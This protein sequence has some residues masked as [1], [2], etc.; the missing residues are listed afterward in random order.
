[1][2]EL[3]GQGKVRWGGVSNFDVDLLERCEA[4]RHVDS[5]QPRLNLIDREALNEVIPWCAQHGVGVV[6][7]APM[8]SGL[9]TGK[10]SRDALDTLAAD[11]WRR[12]A[13]HFQDSDLS[14]N[15]DLVDRLRPIAARLDTSLAALAVGWTLTVP[16]VTGAI[17][18]A[19]SASQV[20]GWLPAAAVGLTPHDMRDIE[21]AVA[22]T[23]VVD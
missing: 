9:L 3:I 19:R 22:T 6:V 20:D 7:Y 1:L 4:I 5:Y 8:A 18:G 2:G 11:D 13:A 15:L 17:V 10:F 12:R 23:E 21:R 14:R 16:G